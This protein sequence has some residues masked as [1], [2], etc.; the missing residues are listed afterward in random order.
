V[1]AGTRAGEKPVGAASEAAT[2]SL[3]DT[4]DKCK[5]G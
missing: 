3:R 2:S 5:R 4:V 1:G